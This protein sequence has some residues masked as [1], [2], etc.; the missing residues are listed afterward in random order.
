MSRKWQK[1]IEYLS[2]HHPA[3]LGIALLC[4]SGSFCPSILSLFY[5]LEFFKTH[6]KPADSPKATEVGCRA[7]LIPL[8]TNVLVIVL[9]RFFFYIMYVTLCLTKVITS[10]WNC[11]SSVSTYSHIGLVTGENVAVEMDKKR[12]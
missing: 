12:T 7:A 11:L 1:Q 5:L 9:L 6:L 8:L 10:F 4:Y 3:R 2:K